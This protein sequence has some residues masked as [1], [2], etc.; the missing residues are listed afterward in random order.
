MR[1]ISFS[2]LAL[3]ISTSTSELTR[4]E[5]LDQ[6]GEVV[7][8]MGDGAIFD[9]DYTCTSNGLPPIDVVIAGQD[10]PIAVDG[11]VCCGGNS[12]TTAFTRPEISSDE[13]EKQGGFVVNDIGDGAIHRDDYLCEVTGVPP[14][15]TVVPQRGEP[16]AREGQVC[17][18][19][20][21][22][23]KVQREEFTRRQCLNNNGIVVGDIGDGAIFEDGYV[24]E[25]NGLPPLAN[26]VQRGGPNAIEGEVCC[27][28]G[29]QGET[30]PVRNGITR[31]E[32]E[33]QGGTIV[34]D[35][36]DGA[37]FEDGYVCESNGLPPLANISQSG[38]SLAI[39]GE[40]CCEGG[41]A[42]PIATTREEITRD[43]CEAQGGTIVGDIGDGAI[44]EDGYVCE[45]NGLPPLANISQSGESLAIEGE[46]CCGQASQVE[47]TPVRNEITR[48]ECEAQGGTI[49]GDIGDGAIFEDDYVCKSDGLP[50]LANIIQSGESLAIEG[51]VCCGA[52]VNMTGPVMRNEISWE[53]CEDQG[54]EIVGDIGDG[55]IFEDNYLCESNGLPPLANI[56]R[57]EA[58]TIE[59]EVCCAGGTNITRTNTTGPADLDEITRTECEDQGG[60]IIGDIGDGAVLSD[61]YVCESNGEPPIA[62]VVAGPGEPIASEGEVCCGPAINRT[63]S[64][65]EDG[66]SLVSLGYVAGLLMALF[67][68]I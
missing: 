36:G 48:D 27:G 47:T 2:I 8:D 4:Q 15:G 43:E 6:G 19:I 31:D 32:C 67:W 22:E 29:S 11:E 53:E 45:S 54:G 9:Q 56:I 41:T 13:C 5:C 16:M 20:P 50:P 59:G 62:I 64:N 7:G 25:S 1:F 23:D 33:A 52:S 24:C 66:A 49:V 34:G 18:P 37:I 51:E 21:E 63:E 28:Q 58:F 14:I 3:Y 38:E 60:K 55:A 39:E 68:V 42:T 30:T 61:S 10:E 44:F 35:I 40:V 57:D 65:L 46:V 17:C 26:I 12:T